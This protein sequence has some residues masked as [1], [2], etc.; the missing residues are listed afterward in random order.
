[1]SFEEEFDYERIIFRTQMANVLGKLKKEGFFAQ[2]GLEKLYIIPFNDEDNV[3]IEEL[4]GTYLMM[5]FNG[6]AYENEYLE[7]LK[8]VMD[9]PFDK[10]KIREYFAK[11]IYLK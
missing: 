9:E 2:F 5:S 6:E 11:H 4:I 3:P 1:M 7:Y 10:M 8:S